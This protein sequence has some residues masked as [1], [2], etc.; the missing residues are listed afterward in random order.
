MP[1][2]KEITQQYLEAIRKDKSPR[3]LDTYIAEQELKDHIAMYEV[4]PPGYWIE[5]HQMIAE[6]DLVNVYGTIHGVHNGPL[7]NI[8][9]T[10]KTVNFSIFITYKFA[11]GKIVAHWMVVDMMSLMQQIGAFPVPSTA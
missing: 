6:G 7:M 2:N 8:Q 9:P 5:P 11:N 1:T 4:S 10:H 3:T